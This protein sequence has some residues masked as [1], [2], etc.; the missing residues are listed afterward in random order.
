MPNLKN[1]LNDMSKAREFL[2]NEKAFMDS[3]YINRY[4]LLRRIL[5]K[6]NGNNLHLLN[7][8]KNI[9]SKNKIDKIFLSNE[10]KKE[11]LRILSKD[12]ETELIILH[13][14]LFKIGFNVNE[15]GK[16]QVKNFMNNCTE[17][18]IKRNLKFMKRKVEQILSNV[19]KFHIE[20]NELSLN[21][22][23]IYPSIRNTKLSSRTKFLEETFIDFIKSIES[24]S[25]I[26]KNNL[27]S[28]IH[29]KSRENYYA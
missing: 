6:I 16:I 27:L 7:D 10:D 21:V 4:N 17:I 19:F 15:V 8:I 1:H 18:K 29:K 13:C 23:F 14:L 22:F 5:L 26:T 12:N 24:I 25:T 9:E 28:N 2:F 3:T 20:K 11:Y